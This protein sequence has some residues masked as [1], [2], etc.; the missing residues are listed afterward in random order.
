MY[1]GINYLKIKKTLILHISIRKLSKLR[2]GPHVQE[3]TLKISIE[4]GIYWNHL[5]HYCQLPFLL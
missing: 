4:N 2:H 5:S 1:L 3:N